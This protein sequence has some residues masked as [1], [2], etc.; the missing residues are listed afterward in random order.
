MKKA[1]PLRVGGADAAVEEALRAAQPP[2]SVHG[3]LPLPS[4]T[5]GAA[6]DCSEVLAF[7]D[8]PPAATKAEAGAVQNKAAKADAT[9]AGTRVSLAFGQIK[10]GAD[11][12]H[13]AEKF[14]ELDVQTT[15][16]AGVSPM[17]VM[18]HCDE[19]GKL[20]D[21]MRGRLVIELLTMGVATRTKGVVSKRQSVPERPPRPTGATRSTTP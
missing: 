12:V 20:I 15:F 11:F 13:G 9:V 18:L 3:A 21:D 8:N 14:P 16:C 2:S 4:S 5:L 17:N 6:D 10:H 7:N 19:D 1:V